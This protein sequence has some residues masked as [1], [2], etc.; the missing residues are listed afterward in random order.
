MQVEKALNFTLVFGLGK[1]YLVAT[2]G[3][4]W[5]EGCVAVQIL[6]VH[7]TCSFWL[8]NGRAGVLSFVMVLARLL[9]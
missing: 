4:S 9:F 8:T 5:W 6:I 3:C 2:L 1:S 7:S